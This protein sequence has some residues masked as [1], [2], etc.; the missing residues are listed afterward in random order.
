LFNED[1]ILKRV[2]QGNLKAFETIFRT[3][4][5]DLCNYAYQYFH[6]KDTVEEIVQDLFFKLWSKKETLNIRSSLR[7]YLYKAVYNNSMLYLREKNARN[8]V[9]EIG[10]DIEQ[11]LIDEPD[12]PIQTKELDQIINQTIVSMP[13]KVRQIFELS[14]QE[15]LRYKDI[16]EKLSISVKTVEANMS[17]ALKLF[18]ENLKKYM[19]I[20][21]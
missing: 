8:L 6:D 13:P 18:R 14:R 15:G 7:S 20:R 4:Y 3:Y 17:K 19:E 1:K 12:I 10:D 16:A 9:Y 11:N 2:R 5:Q 21:C